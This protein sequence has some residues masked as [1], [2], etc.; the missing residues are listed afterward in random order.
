MDPTELRRLAG[1]TGTAL[2]IL[3]KDQALTLVLG[4]LAREPCARDLAFK[5]GT[6]LSK[7]YFEGYGSPRTSTSPRCAMSRTTSRRPHLASWRPGGARGCA[8]RASSACRAG[9][10]GAP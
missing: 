8:S 9:G 4:V 10:A 7:M 1:R 3:E 5:G 2:G 6:A